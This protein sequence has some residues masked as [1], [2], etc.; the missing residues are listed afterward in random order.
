MYG[1]RTKL[2]AG[3]VALVIVFA[4]GGGALGATWTSDV[5]EGWS[6]ADGSSLTAAGILGN[7]QA[8]L[9]D[10]VSAP[11]CFAD[12][13][14]A[15]GDLK[16]FSVYFGSDFPATVGSITS[17]T[18]YID[19]QGPAAKTGTL[20]AHVSDDRT[21]SGWYTGATNGS[22]ANSI[23]VAWGD[24]ELTYAY[25]VTSVLD[26]PAKINNCELLVLDA[27]TS[28]DKVYFDY[29]RI[30]VVYE[31]PAVDDPS[32]IPGLQL[33]LDGQDVDGNGAADSITDGDP[34]GS[35]VDK[36]GNVN[37]A[38]QGTPANQPTYVTSDPLLSSRPVVRFDSTVKQLAFTAPV[39]GS[40]G[41]DS[42]VFILF[43]QTTPQG[44]WVNPL[45]ASAEWLHMI[46]TSNNRCL[47][48]GGGQPS[49]ASSLPAATW[50]IQTCQLSVGDYQL[51]IDGVSQGTSTDTNFLNPFEFVGSNTVM[52][53]AEVVIYDSVLSAADRQDVEA[54]L[55]A[56][57]W[58]SGS[59][60][61]VAHYRFDEAALSATAIDETGNYDATVSDPANMPGQTGMLLGAYRFIAADADDYIDSGAK[62]LTNAGEYT[63]AGWVNAAVF[64][65]GSP[66]GLWGQNDNSEFGFQNGNLEWWTQN[67]SNK[68]SVAYPH[69]AGEWHHIAAVAG[70]G[71]AKTLYI[72]GVEAVSNTNF[73][74]AST[75]AGYN[76]K[77]GGTG[78]TA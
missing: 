21:T 55:G 70:P 56:K 65:Q 71:N 58:A 40:S 7:I 44:L 52:D 11:V 9:D 14:D 5:V 62:L 10:G 18:I 16:W 25:D 67:G 1:F 26:T 20:V 17:V 22:T 28:D 19:H 24:T 50:A 46:N 27:N 30:E 76:F 42:T 15:I 41:S 12:K 75:N 13:G 77:I 43:R 4:G 57:W 60:N 38:T 2:A 39:G 61:L 48:K 37:N 53:V 78:S 49:V 33:W 64:P 31:P 73:G 74:G 47:T 45:H 8:D 54:Y 35:W 69:P 63:M 51:W 59:P 34:I 3:L 23:G 36:S 66:I 32:D 72:D 6:T 68:I 29:M